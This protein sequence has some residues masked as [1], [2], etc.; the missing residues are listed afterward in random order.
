MV[1]DAFRFVYLVAEHAGLPCP[2]SFP[3]LLD[4]FFREDFSILEYRERR[5]SPCVLAV[6]L[7][8]SS[9]YLFVSSLYCSR[10]PG[11]IKRLPS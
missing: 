2:F 6:P 5:S 8:G 7:H 11:F 9:K 4:A 10:F 3:D 1:A